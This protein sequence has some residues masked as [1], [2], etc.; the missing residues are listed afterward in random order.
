MLVQHSF[1]TPT[2]LLYSFHLVRLTTLEL[3]PSIYP[4]CG[5]KEIEPPLSLN[6]LVSS[7]T[8]SSSPSPPF[9]SH[10]TC[11][12]MGVPK[13][14]R[15]LSERYPKINERAGFLPEK[16]TC[17]RHFGELPPDPILPPDPLSTCGL[18]PPIDRLYID[19]NGV[20]HG[21]SHNN[22]TLPQPLTQDGIFRNIAYYLDRIVGDIVKPTELVYLSVDGVAPRAKLNQ[23]R[24]RRYR[25]GNEGEIEETIYEAHLLNRHDGEEFDKE[26]RTV[27]E[28][29]ALKEVEPGRFTGKFESHAEIDR[30]DS[31]GDFHHN[32]ITPGTSFF[33]DCTAFLEQHIEEKVSSDP[34]WRHL[35]V[36]FSGPNVPGEGEHK[37]MDFV[38][39]E[40]KR[41]DYNPNLRHC[42]MGQDGDWI[43][44]GLA[45]HEPNLVLLR[46]QVIFDSDR[47]NIVERGGIESYVHNPNFEWL[48]MGILRDYLAYEFETSNVVPTSHYELE[49]TLDDFVF[50]TFFVGND[51]L[52]HMPA[53]DIADEAFDLLFYT[54]RRQ[55][56]MWRKEKHKQPPYLTHA[57]NIVSGKRLETFFAHLG[58]HEF[59]YYDNKKRTLNET[60]AKMRKTDSKAGACGGC[61]CRGALCLPQ[62]AG[63]Y[64]CFLLDSRVS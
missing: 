18:P 25:S 63:V 4:P 44:L 17:I 50:L 57:G 46:E 20:I 33:Q 51:F 8:D 32:A 39:R 38:R 3:T 11:Y 34:N 53:L 1:S 15:W 36:I 29:D 49:A 7:A 43:M 55:R 58:Q 42:I 22:S 10:S 27:N 14:F 28:S 31:M 35:T 61:N 9:I 45:T 59:P 41:P 6:S 37:I 30:S 48:H 62:L 23:Q 60:N 54:Y 19:M 12:N 13:F 5:W 64:L 40:K 2:P 21:C 47:R 56:K 26:N 16:D 24:S 52:P